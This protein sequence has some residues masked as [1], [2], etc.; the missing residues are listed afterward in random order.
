MMGLT[1]FW[2]EVAVG[3]CQNRTRH[4]IAICAVQYSL[5]F[6]R[7][8]CVVSAFPSNSRNFPRG[9]RGLCW[10]WSQNQLLP[11]F[12]LHFPEEVG[13]RLICWMMVWS[14][15]LSSAAS[16][17]AFEITS[18]SLESPSNGRL[19]V[20]APGLSLADGTMHR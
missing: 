13:H 1:L 17:M 19:S 2:N 18:D 15:I 16:K 10:G 12:A 6:R 7:I 20:A 8:C 4:A 9:C 5:N 14:V 3:C 11:A